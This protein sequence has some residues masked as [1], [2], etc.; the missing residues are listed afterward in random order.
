MS[1]ETTFVLE[2]NDVRNLIRDRK[3]IELRSYLAEMYEADIAELMNDLNDKVL[4]LLLFRML[5]KLKAVEVFSFLSIDNQREIISAISDSELPDIID[6][7]F[8]DDVIDMIEEMPAEFVNRVLI[9]IAPEKR[10]LVNQFLNYPED[11]AGTLMT[12]EYVRL[13]EH[14]TVAQALYHVRETGLKKETVYT[15]YITNMHEKLIGIVSLRALVTE[16]PNL[17]ITDIMEKDIIVVNTHDDQELVADMFKRYDLLAMPVVDNLGRLTGIITVDDIIDVMEQEATE[18][19][20]IMAAITPSETEYLDTSIFVLAKHRIVWLLVLLVSATFTGNIMK[21]FSNTLESLIL[22]GM[23]IPM[24]MDTG[25]NAGSQS[26]T[27]IIR[28][29]ATGGIKLSDAFKVLRKE[30]WLSL[31]CG[32][33]LSLVN[34]GRI[35]IFEPQVPTLV[36]LTVS[37]TLITTVVMAKVIGGLLPIA[38]KKLKLD[39]AIMAGP[40]ITTVVDAMSLII[41]F[42]VAQAILHI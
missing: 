33:I 4:A 35:L 3:I 17:K 29:L 8:F 39:P 19:F 5:P 38:A 34:F 27:L 21:N 32:V 28:G 15:C 13:T 31:I 14:M 30:F 11:S 9:N 1:E 2:K 40:L 22:L 41:Y 25:G 18:D 42:N 24:L 12:I 16:D 26:S 36:A 10:K 23:F 6:N 20:Q 37:L 7:V